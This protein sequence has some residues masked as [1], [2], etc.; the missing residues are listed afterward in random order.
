MVRTPIGSLRQAIGQRV[1]IQGWLQTLRDQK[2]MQ[3]LIIRDRTGAVQVVFEKKAD[4]ELAEK[5]SALGTESTV[6]LT[7]QVVD[8][9]VVKLGGL[10]MQLDA[11]EVDNAAESPLPFEPFGDTLPSPDFRMDWR[12]IDLRRPESQLITRVQTTA[13]MAMR[14][15]W[16]EHGFVE[17][18]SPKIVSSP[19][20]GGAELFELTYFD[21]KA[22]LAQSPQF[23]KQMAMAGGLDRVFE[24]GPAFRADPS[25][26]SRHM[27]EFISIDIEMA[28]IDSHEDVMAFQ[29]RWLQYV[30]Q[31]VK[32]AHADEIKAVF[33]RE[34]DV[35]TVPFPRIPMAQAIEILKEMGYQLP[36]E[37]KGDIDHGGER[38]IAQYVKEKYDHD[39]VFLTD[40]PISV[41]PFYHMRHP[42]NP[43]L[44]RSFDL[45]GCGLEIT[46]GA[47]REHRYEILCQQA[48][49]KGLHLEPIQ[50]YLDFFRYGCPS[51]GGLGLGL[52]RLLMILL[53]LGSVRDAVF[54]FR[55]PNRLSP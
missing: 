7:G 16:L 53:G 52:A 5:I 32:D 55:G 6:S 10:E 25:F 24:I 15:Y 51:H 48:L 37:K 22:Y 3:F 11:L 18:H 17:I 38:A 35:P 46:T 49:E 47:Q 23:Y 42:D 14:E 50:F 45:I 40:W 21:R 27:T 36:P 4:P 31:R 29:E 26:T 19:S 39:F 34:I 13:E 1:K 28:W 8:N 2:K 33:D 43:G 44:T 30:Y 41:R 9:P 20:E 54:L 12:S